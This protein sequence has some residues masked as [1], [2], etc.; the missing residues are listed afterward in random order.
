MLIQVTSPRP[1]FNASESPQH[2]RIHTI[3]KLTVSKGEVTLVVGEKQMDVEPFTVYPLDGEPSFEALD[4]YLPFWRVFGTDK[5]VYDE[6]RIRSNIDKGK[7]QR[8]TMKA[9]MTGEALVLKDE[10][11]EKLTGVQLALLGSTGYHVIIKSAYRKEG[12]AYEERTLNLTI[13]CAV[14]GGGMIRVA[15][16]PLDIAN[17][18][19]DPYAPPPADRSKDLVLHEAFNRTHRLRTSN[20]DDR[21]RARI[22]EAEANIRAHER[23]LPAKGSDDD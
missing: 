3:R 2:V 10:K 16:C 13:H 4:Y 12:A 20:I 1:M 17:P 18:S 14:N 22:A 8:V 15:D 21:R 9:D 6:A 23:G 7:F 19:F 11:S 5:P